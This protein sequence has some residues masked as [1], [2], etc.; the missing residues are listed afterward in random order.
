MAG[1]E[2]GWA[3]ASAA[4]PRLRTG[5]GSSATASV[6]QIL[7]ALS[8]FA[9]NRLRPLGWHLD[10][11]GLVVDLAELKLDDFGPCAQALIEVGAVVEVD[12]IVVRLAHADEPVMVATRQVLDAC[13]QLWFATR[14]RLRK[15]PPAVFLPIVFQSRLLVETAEEAVSA[16]IWLALNEGVHFINDHIERRAAQLPLRDSICTL[17]D[18]LW[19][20]SEALATC[21]AAAPDQPELLGRPFRLLRGASIHARALAGD[22]AA[23]EM[24]DGQRLAA[25]TDKI[26]MMFDSLPPCAPLPTVDLAPLAKPR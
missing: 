14:Q 20:A 1:A 8:R 12:R 25:M 18:D 3:L 2:L 26:R 21:A 7:P 4:D 16:V 19:L 23:S 22:P 13:L 24:V 9:T 6:L 5:G 15:L 17:A 10:G 11:D